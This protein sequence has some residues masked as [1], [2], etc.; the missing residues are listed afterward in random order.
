MNKINRIKIRISG[1]FVLTASLFWF[2]DTDGYLIYTLVAALVHEAGHIAAV[3]LYGGSIKRLRAFLCGLCIEYDNVLTPAG[4]AVITLA[5]PIMNFIFAFIAYTCLG[6]NSIS[7]ISLAQGVFNML[8]IR[9]MDGGRI[10][11]LTVKNERVCIWTDRVFIIIICLIAAHSWYTGM[12]PNL[13]VLA[14]WLIFDRV[15][16]KARLKSYNN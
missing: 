15:L 10:L 13:A 11:S 4:E 12:A 5:G 8:P 1:G 9:E 16:A 3:Y 2:F 14:V 7:A 6:S